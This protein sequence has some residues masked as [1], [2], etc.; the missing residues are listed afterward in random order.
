MNSEKE[1]N[2]VHEA[3]SAGLFLSPG[4]KISLLVDYIR[5][6]VLMGNSAATADFLPTVTSAPASNY[7]MGRPVENSMNSLSF[8]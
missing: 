3:R 6:A 5:L 2:N 7:R 1:I 4:M 8:T